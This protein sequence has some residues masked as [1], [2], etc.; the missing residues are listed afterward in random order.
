MRKSRVKFG[1]G[2]QRKLLIRGRGALSRKAVYPWPY[3]AA[4]VPRRVLN[5]I[6]NE[7]DGVFGA[8]IETVQKMAEPSALA[9]L[10]AGTSGSAS[11]QS[12][13]KSL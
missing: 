4:S 10:R 11:R 13:N 12:F 7:C 9:C 1:S 5:V 2:L 6:R 3:S 8:R